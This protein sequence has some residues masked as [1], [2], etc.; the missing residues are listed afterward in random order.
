MWTIT[1]LHDSLMFCPSWETSIEWQ[2]AII[3]PKRVPAVGLPSVAASTGTENSRN[4]TQ[5]SQQDLNLLSEEKAAAVSIQ[6]TGDVG[7]G[8]CARKG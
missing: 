4:L 1:T 6:L 3:T 8:G 2:L 5:K 7:N